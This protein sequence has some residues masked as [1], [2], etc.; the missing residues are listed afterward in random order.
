[1]IVE[2]NQIRRATMRRVYHWMTTWGNYDKIHLQ[3]TSDKL[4]PEKAPDS[5]IIGHW[6][7]LM[8]LSHN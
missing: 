8:T 2:I 1:M 7:E 4:C 3:A 5:V 6:D